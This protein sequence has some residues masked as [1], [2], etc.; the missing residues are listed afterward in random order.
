[1]IH[2]AIGTDTYGAVRRLGRTSVVTKFF[3]LQALPIYP[4]ESYYLV[5]LG[6][7]FA[8]GVPLLACETQR[9][10][11][12]I[13]CRKINR[14]SVIVAYARALAAVMVIF[15][16]IVFFMAVIMRLCDA[17]FHPDEFVQLIE[18]IAGVVLVLGLALALPT[19]YLT[20]HVPQREAGIRRACARVLGVAADPAHVHPD[21][22][23]EIG[24]QV[25]ELLAQRGITD[26]DGILQR[27]HSFSRDVLDLAL[28]RTRARLGLGDAPEKHEFGTDS[29]LRAIALAA[30]R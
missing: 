30:G 3:M 25:D 23:P 21:I 28:A 8:S 26:L 27:P 5:R 12:G 11:I 13:R 14:L 1:M 15:P 18:W 19:Y 10:I 24:K 29:L 4:L 16:S 2:V 6:R 17:N 9:K 7:T 22:V 20:F